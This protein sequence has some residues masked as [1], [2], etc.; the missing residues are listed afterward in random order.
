MPERRRAG[1][2]ITRIVSVAVAVVAVG[3]VAW[4]VV[5]RSREARRAAVV[6]NAST[7]PAVLE[8]GLSE[9]DARALLIV[10]P[11]LTARMTPAPQPVTEAEAKELLAFLE[12]T[13]TGF[14]RFS[15]Y[16][17]V[18]SLMLVTKILE[19]F[20]VDEAPP[21]W[22]AALRPAHDVLA[23]GLADGDLQTRLTAL[24]QVAQFWNW[25]PGRS[26]MPLEE[27]TLV[28]W[29]GALYAPVVRRLGDREP[30]ARAAAVACLGSL[31]DDKAAAE[32]L[33]YLEDSGTGGGIVRQ[34]VLVSFAQRPILLSEEMILRRL[35]DSEPAIVET[36]DLILKGRGLN[37]EQIELGRLI[38]DPKPEHRAAVIPRLRDRT[39]IDP[40]IWLL[41]L[42]RDENETIRLS[43]A[44]AL[45]ER[46]TPEVLQRL[47]EMA[48]TDRS[49]TVRQ[50]VGKLVASAPKSDSATALP[51]PLPRSARGA[52]SLA[53]GSEATVVLP[54]LPGATSLN[55]KAN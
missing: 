3:A 13:R 14:L 12:S 33:A 23:S 47:T 38:F 37:A 49:A 25:F 54:P 41:E 43:A 21:S 2:W 44:G 1:L 29:K 36:A 40:V 48:R 42:S 24:N 11:R 34:Q 15:G 31:P 53:A 30:Q 5:V 46:P 55:P 4:L 10:F 28:G 16:G 51:L 7:P 35:H 17:R 6:Y 26:M 9:G 32:A 19:R 27:S 20:A 18:S 50:A 22:F 45:A 52:E 39:D 8:N